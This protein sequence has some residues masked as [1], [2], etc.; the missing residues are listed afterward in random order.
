MDRIS[1]IIPVY[2]AEKYLRACLDSVLTQTYP[3]Y[4]IILVDDGSSDDSGAVCDKYAARDPRIRVIHKANAG[5]SAARNDGL[6]VATGDWISFI[7]SD[8]TMEP[9]M[10]EL[11]LNTAKK[12]GAEISHCGYKRMT[13]AGELVKEVSGTHLVL[14]QDAVEA[15]ACM[16]DGRYFVGGLWNKL[17]YRK[18]IEGL[19]FQPDLRNNEDVL[20]NAM[21]FQNADKI[22]FIDETKY[23]YYEHSASACN[24]MD[25]ERQCRDA[26]EAAERMYA[27]C[28]TAEMRKIAQRWRFMTRSGLYRCLLLRRTGTAAEMES[29]RL[30]LKENACAAYQ[31]EKR[32]KLGQYLM[33]NMAGLYRWVYKVYDYV[34]KPNWDV[35]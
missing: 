20:F 15:V 2:N 13:E 28:E 26:V 21:A 17:F 7:D 29:L 32:T 27:C 19:R 5:V 1:V 25:G 11:L 30:W 31:L 34:R 35:K 10:Y 16:L 9:D 33:L 12:Y 18:C 6:S 24:K 22:V 3:A 23:R 8:D 14:E 4:E